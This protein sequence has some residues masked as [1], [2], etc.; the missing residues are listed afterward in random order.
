MGVIF[1]IICALL[2][3]VAPAWL[4]FIISLIN[5]LMPDPIPFVDEVLMWGVWFARI[6]R[7]A[8]IVNKS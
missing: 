8:R 5:T 4:Q 3:C 1:L 6:A 7:V 2:Y